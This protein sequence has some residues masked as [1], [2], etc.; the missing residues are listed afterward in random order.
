MLGKVQ[1]A[2]AAEVMRR[3][4]HQLSGGMQQR[5]VIAMALATDPDLLIMDEPTTGLDVTVEAAVLDL[6]ADLR[7]EFRSAILL[8]SH[9]LGVI[10]RV[11]DRVGV[12][13]AGELI[14]QGT[15][16]EIFLT[17]R[18][19]YTVGL[20]GSLPR[21]GQH[22]RVGGEHAATVLPIRPIPGRMPS[23]RALP[24]GCAFAPRCFMASPVCN[25][26][27]PPLERT[28]ATQASRCLFWQEVLLPDIVMET[29]PSI[30]SAPHPVGQIRDDAPLLQIVD[31]RKEFRQAGA[32]GVLGGKGR[33]V[34][35]VDGISFDLAHGTTLGIV[36]ESG[37]GK[38]TLARCVAGSDR[39]DVG[40]TG[41]RG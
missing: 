7:H 5:V 31:L 40:E 6:V 20:L 41:L 1:V 28:T 34:K 3:Y 18:H 33:T 12:M 4:P 25:D 10:A 19:P 2:D 21:L 22:R 32:L 15:S 26:A 38:S 29:R 35:A 39:T 36:G 13:Y 24:P 9:N 37:C 27:H 11:C 17:P 16:E 14:E 8:I 30:D 23:P